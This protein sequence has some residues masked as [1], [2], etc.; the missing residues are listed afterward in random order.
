MKKA[1]LFRLIVITFFCMATLAIKS[2]TVF[3]KTICYSIK[4]DSIP[5]HLKIL[6]TGNGIS[7]YKYDAFFIK[8]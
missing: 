3:S 6:N 5:V 1:F 2:E 4:K 8:I 7:H